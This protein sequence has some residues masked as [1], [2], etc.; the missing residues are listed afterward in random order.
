MRAYER[1]VQEAVNDARPRLIN[2]VDDGSRRARLGE[3]VACD[4][5]CCAFGF[6][7]HMSVDLHRDHARSI[8]DKFLRRFGMHIPQ[9]NREEVRAA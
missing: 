9:G 6:H 8:D 5:H 4:V 3:E 2:Q 7:I 1:K